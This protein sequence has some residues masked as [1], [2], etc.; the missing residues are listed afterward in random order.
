MSFWD[1]LFSNCT[2]G[3]ILNHK[4]TLIAEI[5]ASVRGKAR[6]IQG[7]GA[8][9]DCRRHCPIG[10]GGGGRNLMAIPLLAL[11]VRFVEV[12]ELHQMA[13]EAGCQNGFAP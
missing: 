7:V 8:F 6:S 9:R 13:Q 4:R 5:R 11:K 12:C 10:Q 3:L 2:G 1:E